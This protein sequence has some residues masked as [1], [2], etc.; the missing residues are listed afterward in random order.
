[1]GVQL[2][3]FRRPLGQSSRVQ[4][5]P[6]GGAIGGR[7]MRPEIVGNA[8][9]AMRGI[10][11]P[12]G[13]DRCSICGGNNLLSVLVGCRGYITDIGTVNPAGNRTRMYAKP[14]G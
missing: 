4:N 2:R 14:T 3:F 5:A 13:N 11:M 6:D 12:V 9:R 7:E 8:L 1:M 10:G